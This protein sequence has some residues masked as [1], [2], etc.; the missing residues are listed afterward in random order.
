MPQIDPVSTM[1]RVKHFAFLTSQGA[2]RGMARAVEA[3]S[4]RRQPY[5]F[6][7]ARYP[8]YRFLRH[9]APASA[10]GPAPE[11]IVTF[12]TGANPLPEVRARNLETLRS[13]AGVPVELIT[14]ENLQDWILPDAPLH[15]AFE[16]LSLTHRS[17]YLRAYVLH[18]HGGGYCD[19]KTT[20]SSWAGAFAALA[21][22]SDAWVVGYQEDS[23]GRL[24]S[25]AGQLHGDLRRHF[26]L[27]RGTGAMIARPHSPWTTEWLA[28][29]HRRMDYFQDMLQACPGGVRD[30]APSYP[31]GWTQLLA[32][33]LYPL[34]LKYSDRILVD[35]ALTPSI[36]YYR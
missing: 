16:H 9:N 22:T 5:V 19:I 32:D 27:V 8:E 6:D 23:P 2:L 14:P 30:E 17:D 4:D 15:P 10:L 21:A 13:S 26:H 29:V 33:I 7:A 1:K 25:Y 3:W 35:P 20:A 31:V 36:E 34:A 28:E 12:W 11:R 18:H 24:P